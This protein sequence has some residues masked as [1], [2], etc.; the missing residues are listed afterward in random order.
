MYLIHVFLKDETSIELLIGSAFFLGLIYQ[1][2]REL[3]LQVLSNFWE[4]NDLTCE[5]DFMSFIQEIGEVVDYWNNEENMLRG[6]G[7]SPILR[8]ELNVFYKQIQE[9][10]VSDISSIALF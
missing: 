7:L 6:F 1:P 4:D 3:H 2:A 10:S 9:I 8:D 5:I